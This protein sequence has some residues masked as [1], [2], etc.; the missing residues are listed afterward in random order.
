MGHVCTLGWQA[1]LDGISFLLAGSPVVTV[2]EAHSTGVMVGDLADGQVDGLAPGCVNG[3]D[4]LAPGGV[5]Y[6]HRV[7]VGWR[8]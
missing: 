8:N 1:R 6:F 4:G 7:H 5:W 3:V 2:G